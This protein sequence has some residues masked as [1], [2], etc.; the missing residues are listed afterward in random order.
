MDLLTSISEDEITGAAKFFITEADYS[1]LKK[2]ARDLGM[3]PKLVGDIITDKNIDIDLIITSASHSE[4]DINK[5]DPAVGDS[6]GIH[7]YGRS[8]ISLQLTGVL[9]DDYSQAQKKKLITLYEQLFRLSKVARYGVVPNIEFAKCVAQGALT[10]L[11]V[12]DSSQNEDRT[13]ISINMLVV[14]LFIYNPSN[15]GE[16]K[17]TV[18]FNSELAEPM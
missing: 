3:D 18:I 15:S 4:A 11:S 5:I 2:N 17:S 7:Y 6:F 13:D 14:N 10:N 12:S 8:P 9:I 1:F 16:T